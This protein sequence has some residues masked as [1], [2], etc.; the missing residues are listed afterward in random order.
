MSFD[1]RLRRLES[2]A[3]KSDG[4]CPG[5]ITLVQ[6]YCPN[7]GERQPEIPPDAP[8]CNVCGHPHVLV[9]R[10]EIVDSTT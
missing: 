1:S 9:V 7:M 5:G 2:T 4:P 10:E 8:L 3:R 6:S